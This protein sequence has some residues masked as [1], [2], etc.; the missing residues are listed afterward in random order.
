MP[1]PK[2]VSAVRRAASAL[3]LGLAG[4]ALW[5][6]TP[7]LDPRH[8]DA[9]P[10]RVIINRDHLGQTTLTNHVA[11]LNSALAGRSAF[12]GARVD[13]T[14]SEI[15]I[16]RRTILGLPSDATIAL[17]HSAT[18]PIGFDMRPGRLTVAKSGNGLLITLDK[19]RLLSAPGIRF[20]GHDVL[21]GG[22]FINE[23]VQV[24]AA[25]R[26]QHDAAVRRG[27]AIA[28][29]PAVAALCEQRLQA[30]LQAFLANQPGAGPPPTI[31]FAYR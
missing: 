13:R 29:D 28:A 25:Q 23:D 3:L 31:R 14:Y 5:R 2:S 16:V 9:Q 19:P 26:R 27:D 20:L 15:G 8:T 10:E 21:D 18:Y 4:W 17:R 12:V 11:V 7:A 6:L 24:I 22:L 30:F 1:P